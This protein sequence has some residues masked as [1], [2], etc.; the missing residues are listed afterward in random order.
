[1]S[2]RLDVFPQAVE[3]RAT[4]ACSTERRRLTRD[5]SHIIPSTRGSWQTSTLQV[6]QSMLPAANTLVL[7]GG[8]LSSKHCKLNSPGQQIC[9]D[10]TQVSPNRRFK[11]KI[12]R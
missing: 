9:N 4:V 11:S 12:A 1:M 6:G 2:S 5:S 8:A 7:N 3:T 10:R